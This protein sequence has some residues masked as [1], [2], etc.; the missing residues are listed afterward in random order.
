MKLTDKVAIITGAA[1]GMGRAMAKVFFNEGAKLVLADINDQSLRELQTELDPSKNKII[2]IKCDVASENEILNMVRL[3]VEKFGQIDVLV[4]NAGVMDDFIPVDRIVNKQWQ[5]IMDVN[6][7]GPFYAMR[8]VLPIM[9]K[10]GKGVI[11]NIA[12][13]GGLF[14]SRAGAAYTAS[15]H[16]LIGLTKNTGFMYAQKGIRCNAICPGT[17][18]TPSLHDR[19]NAEADPVQA[20]KNFIARQPMG[21][22][23]Q[24]HE[25]A[26][27][28]VFLASDEAIF[29][30]G[31]AYMVD[32]GMTI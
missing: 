9:L 30:T 14:G 6:L 25:I 15:K 16:A 29:A 7:N 18:E 17:V 26:P 28:I 21:R 11:L 31:N 5:H 1:S 32:G 22:L 13:V 27:I 2:Y 10:H 12:S 24:A 20:R 8:A 4:N 19:I 3:C 23:A